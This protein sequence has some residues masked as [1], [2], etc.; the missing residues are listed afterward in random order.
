MLGIAGMYVANKVVKSMGDKA[1]EKSKEK[2]KNSSGRS[3]AGR[4]NPYQDPYGYWGSQADYY[5][6]PGSQYGAPG[7]QYAPYP[8]GH[9][10]AGW[11]GYPPP[12]SVAPGTSVAGSSSAPAGPPYHH[13]G[14]PSSQSESRIQELVEE[15][16]SDNSDDSSDSDDDDDAHE[17]EQVYD[18]P[19]GYIPPAAG[20]G[21]Y[22]GY[23]PP[24]PGVAGMG[25]PGYPP[26]PHHRPYPYPPLPPD[27]RGSSM[28]S[29]LGKLKIPVLMGLAG[30]A[31][32]MLGD[33]GGEGGGG[34]IKGKIAGMMSG[35]LDKN[36]PK[37]G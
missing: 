31:V 17:H 1:E 29:S 33:K 30:L 9:P 6:A 8:G 13:P 14:A 26:G 22:P 16:G 4:H 36:K 35:F 12:G 20:M 28:E 32:E 15:D 24:P 7:S 11:P 10:Y 3:E 23:P 5:G 18:R 27:E 34:G 21:A 2:V 19:P 25:H 37:E